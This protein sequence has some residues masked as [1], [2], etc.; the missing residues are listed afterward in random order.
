MA[1]GYLSGESCDSDMYARHCRQSRDP[2][3]DSYIN[4]NGYELV[5]YISSYITKPHP[6]LIDQ[7]VSSV[8]ADKIIIDAHNDMLS[9][10]NP[11]SDSMEH[12]VIEPQSL[13]LNRTQLIQLLDAFHQ[14]NSEYLISSKDYI[15]AVIADYLASDKIGQSQDWCPP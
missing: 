8:I 15:D 1:D 13:I 11:L 3:L 7:Y 5:A 9:D 4:V 14:A 2:L 12:L 6:P 10:T